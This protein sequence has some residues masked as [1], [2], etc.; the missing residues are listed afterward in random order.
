MREHDAESAALDAWSTMAWKAPR[1][2]RDAVEMHHV[3]LHNTP[4]DCVQAA[5]SWLRSCKDPLT[6]SPE[7]PLHRPPHD[8]PAVHTLL[9]RKTAVFT[10]TVIHGLC[11]NE[12]VI[13]GRQ[14]TGLSESNPMVT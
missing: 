12:M 11:N 5:D 9:A 4:K 14:T 10:E 13:Q 8:A 6:R 7:T 3:P 2:C 1:T